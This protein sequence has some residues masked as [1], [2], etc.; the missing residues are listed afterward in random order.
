LFVE[1]QKLTKEKRLQ[2]LRKELDDRG[3]EELTFRPVVH[4]APALIHEIA[5]EVRKARAVANAAPLTAGGK[6]ASATPVA[7]PFRF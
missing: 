3:K 6:L 4:E 2:Q 1:M 7:A 5:T